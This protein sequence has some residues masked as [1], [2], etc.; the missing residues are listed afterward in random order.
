[1]RAGRMQQ[2]PVVSLERSDSPALGPSVLAV[3]LRRPNG[4]GEAPFMKIPL[5]GTGRQALGLSLRQFWL[6]ASP[7]PAGRGQGT[8]APEPCPRS[9]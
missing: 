2:V 3:D 9:G 7:P 6:K 5:S 4:N 8:T 1:M